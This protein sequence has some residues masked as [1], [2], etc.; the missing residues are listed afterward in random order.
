MYFA[1]K[2]KHG[3][4]TTVEFEPDGWCSDD[5]AKMQWLTTESGLSNPWPVIP[6]AIRLWL[7]QHCELI[8]FRVIVP[9]CSE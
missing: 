4:G 8:E 6:A 7:Q 9:D 5:P 1:F 3:D 2:W